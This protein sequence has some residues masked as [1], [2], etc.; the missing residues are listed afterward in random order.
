MHKTIDNLRKHAEVLI[1]ITEYDIVW[2]LVILNL[3]VTIPGTLVIFVVIVLYYMQM[4][5]LETDQSTVLLFYGLKYP[6]WQ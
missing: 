1:L 6:I 4:P 3:L 5:I 2:F